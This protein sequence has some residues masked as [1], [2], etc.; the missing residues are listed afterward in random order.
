L[1][2][3]WRRATLTDC[4]IFLWG[5]WLEAHPFHLEALRIAGH[6]GGGAWQ[7]GYFR[8]DP[9]IVNEVAA[10]FCFF[11]AY[12]GRSEFER[13]LTDSQLRSVIN[14]VFSSAKKR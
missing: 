10:S 5:E 3:N 12:L 14:E 9:Q 7:L 8:G 11:S 6:I 2:F 1:A 13:P 4:L